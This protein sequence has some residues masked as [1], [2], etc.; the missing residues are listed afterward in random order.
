MSVIPS[1][2]LLFTVLHILTSLYLCPVPLPEHGR[3][4][5][6]VFSAHPQQGLKASSATSSPTLFAACSHRAVAH[7]PISSKMR[8]QSQH[9]QEQ[10]GSCDSWQVAV[11]RWHQNHE[12]FKCFVH[13]YL[14]SPYV[15][16][17]LT[18][19]ISNHPLLKI[20]PE[21]TELLKTSLIECQYY[22]I[23]HSSDFK[24]T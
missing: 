17:L 5:R 22:Q 1:C 19:R 4:N 24:N 20:F 7:H 21:L 13:H 16:S 11:L 2:A 14:T 23:I 6:K 15:A 9:T 10:S 3:Q 8:E 18:A 12:R